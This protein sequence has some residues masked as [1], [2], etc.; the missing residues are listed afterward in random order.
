MIFVRQILRKFDINTLYICPPH[1]YTVATLQREIQKSHFSTVLFIHRPIS[2]YFRYFGRK[3]TVTPLPTTPENV[4][5]LPCKMHKFFIWL[6]VSCIPPNVGGSEKNRLWCV[7]NGMSGKQRHSKYSKWPPSA[8]IH[9]YS[10]FHHWS[11][12]SSTTLCWNSAHVATRR[13]HNSSVLRI[14]TR[15]AWKKNEKDAKFVHF[16][17]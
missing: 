5:T 1:L 10:L 15:Y 12:A 11:T 9:A 2:D 14:G 7:A 3:Q 16:T 4:T 17:R 6:K 13:F 8:W